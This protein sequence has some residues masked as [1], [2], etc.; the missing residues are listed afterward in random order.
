[1]AK[2]KWYKHLYMSPRI[3]KRRANRIHRIERG[4]FL[5][6][7]Y[8][9]MLSAH[10]DNQLEIM[11]ARFL[12]LPYENPHISMVVGLADSYGEALNL[13]LQISEDAA[14]AGCKGQ[15]KRF[16]LEKEGVG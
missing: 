8:L 7:M 9:L 11:D 10:P 13:L 14:A 15:L 6:G 5:K 1:M 4:R 3:K 2:I 12:Y 16:I